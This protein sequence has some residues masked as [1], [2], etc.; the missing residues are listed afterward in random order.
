MRIR[1]PLIES[2]TFQRF[3]SEVSTVFLR[4]QLPISFKT[5]KVDVDEWAS[6]QELGACK[7]RE[8]SIVVLDDLQW[9]QD[10][11]FLDDEIIQ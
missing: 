9:Y 2:I 6:R 1:S 4:I 11:L 7:Y 3:F 10:L 5:A 8:R